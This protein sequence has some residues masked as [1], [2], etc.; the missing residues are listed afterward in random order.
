MARPKILVVYYSR[1]GITH[2]IAEALCEALTCEREEIVEDGSRAGLF[3]YMRSLVEARQKRPS[4]IAA[5]KR[6]PS[7]YDLVVVG[8]PVW[9][10]PVS[11]PVRAYLIGNRDRVHDV[12]FFCTLGGAGSANAF[13]QM[14]GI[15]GKTPRARLRHHRPRGEIRQLSRTCRGIRKGAGAVCRG[16]RI[17][18][19][20]VISTALLPGTHAKRRKETRI[21][22]F[23]APC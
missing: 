18:P 11:S 1:S 9:G 10:W 8:T 13:T 3:G 6:D 17:G 19:T 21:P 16:A 7:S 22:P 20:R 14:R 4:V 23:S 5:A 12:A 15:T 2:K